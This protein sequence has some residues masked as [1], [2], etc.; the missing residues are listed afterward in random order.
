MAE[1]KQQLVSALLVVLTVAALVA[2]AIN[3]QQQTRYHL[4]DDGVTWVDQADSG[5]EHVVAVYL[6]PS[7]PAQKARMVMR[8]GALTIVSFYSGREGSKF[9][10]GTSMP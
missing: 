9:S 4:P 5:G 7:S 3:F 10:A 6:L 8:V 1:L 2:A